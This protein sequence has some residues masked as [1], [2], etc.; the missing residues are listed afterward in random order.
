MRHALTPH[1]DSDCDAAIRVEVDVVRSR[2]RNLL[3]Q[4]HLTGANNVAM[5]AFGHF[6]RADGLWQ[7]TCFEAFLTAVPGGDYCEFNFAPST[8]WAAYR[9]DGYRNGMRA[10]EDIA[11]PSMTIKRESDLLKLRTDLCLDGLP[12]LPKEATWHLGLSAV[13]EETNGRKSFWALAHPPGKPDFH[14]SD[15]FA[16]ALPPPLQP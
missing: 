1:P 16:L 5:P 9:F 4:Y 6:T 8:Q 7:H 14:H 11:K 10:A 3:L 15:C 13:I 2:N 12:A